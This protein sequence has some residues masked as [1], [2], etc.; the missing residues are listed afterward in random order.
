MRIRRLKLANFRG[1][2]RGEIVFPGHTII[3]SGNS[4]GKSTLCEALDL[5]LGPDR[6]SRS[7][8]ID[9]HDFFECRYLDE[10]GAAIFQ[11]GAQNGPNADIACVYDELRR[12]FLAGPHNILE[13]FE[14]DI[15]TDVLPEPKAIDGCLSYIR[16]CH[17]L[18]VRRQRSWGETGKMVC[19]FLPGQVGLSDFSGKRLGLRQKDGSEKDV[20]T[21]V[22]GLLS[23]A[24]SALFSP[25]CRDMSGPD[26]GGR[27]A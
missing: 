6:L 3:I 22:A 5:L 27:P 15:E 14:R 2:A 17:L 7:N 1:V 19:K 18:R 12:P 21:F 24:E 11:I 8:P 20:Q 10:D 23:M 16:F 13:T 4:V 9:E 25:F 26:L